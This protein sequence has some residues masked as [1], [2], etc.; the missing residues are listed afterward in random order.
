LFHVFGGLVVF[1]FS[2]LTFCVSALEC[3]LGVCLFEKIGNFP[4]FGDVVC[5][6]GPFIS[7]IVFGWLF[8]VHFCF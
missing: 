5:E 6:G 8:V 2:F 3:Y 4:D 1:A 7:S